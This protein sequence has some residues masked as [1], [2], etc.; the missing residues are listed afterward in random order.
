M[1]GV[2]F[3]I[4]QETVKRLGFYKAIT[5]PTYVEIEEWYVGVGSRI[6]GKAD[7]DTGIMQGNKIVRVNAAK[8][9][10]DIIA[11]NEEIGSTLT[12]I[13]IP[14]GKRV[15]IDFRNEPLRLGI[16]ETVGVSGKKREGKEIELPARQEIELEQPATPLAKELAEDLGIA[17][18]SRDEIVRV[19][20]VLGILADSCVRLD[21]LAAPA[22]R[23]L[24]KNFD[25]ILKDVHG[26]GIQGLIMP[27]DVRAMKEEHAAPEMK[28]QRVMEPVT[29][30]DEVEVIRIPVSHLSMAENLQRAWSAPLASPGI[31]INPAPM[32]ELR[33]KMRKRFELVHGVTLRLEY[34]VTAACAW[35]LGQE[36]VKILNA[37]WVDD[38]ENSRIEL[39]KQVNIGIAVAVLPPASRGRFSSLLT[40]VVKRANEKSFVQIAKEADRIIRDAVEGNGATQDQVGATFIVNNTGS[41]VHW[42]WGTAAGDEFPDPIIAPDTA[43]L[44]AFGAARDGGGEKRMRLRLR[45]DH[46]VVNGYE[47]KL[48]IRMLQALLEEPEQIL[49]LI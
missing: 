2:S 1:T 5:G 11:M 39:Y 8:G 26:S 49:T 21:I 35:L 12:E 18:P 48:F 19:D 34:F 3:E 44:L 33:A 15:R 41:P 32:L 6:E 13:F 31:D 22:T 36:E 7:R 29:F 16:I 14:E 10:V 20:D 23:M 30:D 28:H 46:R 27:S 4:T 25:V 47:V 24:A 40:P 43:A 38:R 9:V 17:I 45:F 37:R 42:K